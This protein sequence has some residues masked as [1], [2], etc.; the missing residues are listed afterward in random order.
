[1][2][3]YPYGDANGDGLRTITDSGLMLRDFVDI[4]RI[5]PDDPFFARGV[6]DLDFNRGLV[7]FPQRH[8]ITDI[9]HFLRRFVEIIPE[10]PVVENWRNYPGAPSLVN[11]FP[12][13]NVTRKASLGFKTSGQNATVSVN[14]DN[15]ADVFGAELW[16][17]YDATLLKIVDVS[18]SDCLTE[19]NNKQE[20]ELHIASMLLSDNDSLADIQFELLPGADKSSLSSVKLTKVNLNDGL[21]PVKLE[22]IP[23]RS[24]L[25]QNYPNPFNPET[26]IPYRLNQTADVTI[27]IYDVNGHF[28]RLLHIGEQVPGNY[29]TKD[30]AAYWDGLNE[31]GEKVASGVYFYQFKTNEKSFVKKMILLK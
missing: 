13:L 1:M 25:L 9:G 18:A 5:F 24:M 26:W 27:R 16:L 8:T 14:L 6:G 21:I 30:K 28:I 7:D 10:F 12:A 22:Y 11:A 4:E 31:K 29:V 3:G 19:Y 2:S 15:N 17:T 23:N 20:G